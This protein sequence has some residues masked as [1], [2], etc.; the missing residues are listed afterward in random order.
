MDSGTPHEPPG[1][2]D[3]KAQATPMKVWRWMLL[4]V[5]FLICGAILYGS[6]F[7]ER[8]GFAHLMMISVLPMGLAI[9]S[10]VQIASYLVRSP[11][12]YILVAAY[13]IGL[14]F[15]WGYLVV[16]YGLNPFS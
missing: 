3:G 6:T 5:P 11:W 2:G 8:I 9:V 10:A 15:F 14:Y 13:C 4:P 16:T 7:I 12:R 1:S